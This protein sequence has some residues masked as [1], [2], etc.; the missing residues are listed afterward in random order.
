[1]AP[2]EQLLICGGGRHNP[3]IMAALAAALPCRVLPV[4]AAGL[5]GDMLEAQAFGWLAVRVARGLP[6]SGEATTG[7]PGPVCGGRISGSR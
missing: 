1:P 6:T 4:E 3:T 5:D 2:P 7:A